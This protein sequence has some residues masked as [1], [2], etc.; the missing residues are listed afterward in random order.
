[1]LMFTCGTLSRRS[2]FVTD[3]TSFFGFFLFTTL[4]LG[5]AMGTPFS[6]SFFFLADTL[7]QQENRENV[8]I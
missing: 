2:A 7:G 3:F 1:M 8:K 6:F 4:L 5:L